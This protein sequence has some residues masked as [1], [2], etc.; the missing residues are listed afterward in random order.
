MQT[1]TFD[2]I[3]ETLYTETLPNGLTVHLVPKRGF[4]KTYAVFTTRYGSIDSHFKTIG[5]EEVTVPDGIAHF[6]EHKMFDKKDR[7]VFR[8]FSQNGASYNAFTSFTRTAYLFSSTDN[9]EKNL[10]LLLDFVQEPYF[11]DQSVEKEKGIIGQEITMYDDNPD[12]VVYM[13]LLKAMY[14]EYPVKKEIAGTIE[15]ISHI[16]KETLYQCYETFYHPANM[17]L[18]V[19]GSFDPQ[20]VIQLVRDNQSKKTF[21]PAPKIE[22]IFPQEPSALAKQNVEQHLAVGLPKCLIGF[23]EA[24]N[25]LSGNDLLKR[26]LTTKL[27]LEI[28]FG[29]S[30]PAYQAM[31]DQGI[32][33]DSFDFDYSTERDYA[34]SIIGGDA[35]DPEKLV[36]SIQQVINDALQTGINTEA[37]ERSKRKKIGHFIRACNSVEYIANQFTSYTFNGTDLFS[38]LPVLESITRE[39][40]EQRLREHLRDEQMA[41]SIVRSASRQE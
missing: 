35:P 27:L 2:Q 39:E 6:L 30:S 18:L 41:V 28:L 4:S 36:S 31:Y 10:H 1:K 9:I 12:W 8:E 37:F 21:P 32:I 11:S 15:S 14:Q 33:T 29:A 13:N 34:Y 20:E 23:K 26:E 3:Q 38:V 25:G 19:V 40:V 24:K 5:G 7:D 16:T 17:L 22:R